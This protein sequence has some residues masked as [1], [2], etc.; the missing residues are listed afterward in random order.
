MCGISGAIDHSPSRAVARVRTLNNAQ[1]HRGPDDD[2]IVTIG[3]FTLGNT[4]LAIQDPGPSGNQPFISADGRYHCVFNG[5]IYN[6]RHLIHRYNLTVRTACD[7]EVIPALWAKLGVASLAE[8]RGMFAIALVDSL[9]ERLYLA[10]DPFGIKPLLW[11][12]TPDGVLFASELRP[13]N[14]MCPDTKI[15]SIA[16]AQYLNRGSV[17]SDRTPFRQISSVPPNSV[18]TFGRDSSVQVSPIHPGGP[19]QVAGSSCDLREALADSIALHLGADVP[20]ALLLSSGVDSAAIAATS[21]QLGRDLDCL[22]VATVGMNDESPE[23]ART[24]KHYKHPHRCVKASLRERELQMFFRAMQRPTI[25]GL[26]TYLVCN[27]VHE[28]GFK[29]ALSGLGGDEAVGG[30]SHFQLLRYSRL[31]SYLDKMPKSAVVPAAKLIASLSGRSPDK[32]VRLLTANGPRIGANL[33]LLQREL[34]PQSLAGNLLGV[35][36]NEDF[37]ESVLVPED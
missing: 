30:Y 34:L 26:N 4:R 21:R 29:V 3:A 14:D 20:T 9:E 7:G 22:T 32:T 24:A 13:L 37:A 33:S 15:D 28:A 10:R 8:L 36:I 1:Q 17:S 18:A 6:Y 19:L 16:I 25:D 27:A 2:V 11:K 31:L 5:E 12:K 23:A 35:S